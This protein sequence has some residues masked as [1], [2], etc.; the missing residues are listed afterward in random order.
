MASMTDAV[1]PGR[2][3]THAPWSRGE[4]FG[5]G[6]LNQSVDDAP[7]L[8]ATAEVLYH[9]LKEGFP[10]APREEAW[11]PRAYL[12]VR[13]PLARGD[14]DCTPTPL[15]SAAGITSNSISRDARLY[16]LWIVTGSGTP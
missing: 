7:A 5:V 8:L 10:E 3:L 14:Q 15:C 16:G 1:T 6:N 4:P 11:S 2:S 9:V 13:N 12:P